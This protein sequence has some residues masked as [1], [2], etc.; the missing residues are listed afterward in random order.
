MGKPKKES[1]P[2]W[3]TGKIA[4]TYFYSRLKELPPLDSGQR[5]LL[6]KAAAEHESYVLMQ[7]MIEQQSQ[8]PEGIF[9]PGSNGNLVPHPAL[10]LQQKYGAAL[11]DWE[12]QLRASLETSAPQSTGEKSNLD[13]L[14]EDEE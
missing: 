1:A 6:A 11:R 5:E 8:T 13:R 4:R 14:M 12:K 2:D 9:L 10:G 7:A 3:L